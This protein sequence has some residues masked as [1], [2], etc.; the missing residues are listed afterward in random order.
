M[1]PFD[2]ARLPRIEFGAGAIDRLPEILGRYGKHILI[3]TGARSFIDGPYWPALQR[4]LAALNLSHELVQVDGEPSPGLVD[5]IVRAHR[6]RSLDAD[7]GLAAALDAQAGLGEALRLLVMSATLD[8]ARLRSRLRSARRRAF[9]RSDR[10]R[11]QG[12][13]QAVAPAEVTA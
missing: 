9:C 6:E 1:T 3:V 11:A 8:G 7:L 12:N 2:I 5:D 4:R 13:L 10:G